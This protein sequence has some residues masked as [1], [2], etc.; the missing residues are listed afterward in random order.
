MD[1]LAT[2]Y[3]LLSHAVPAGTDVT[4]EKSTRDFTNAAY[5]SQGLRSPQ[6]TAICRNPPKYSVA[7]D[8]KT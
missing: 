4:Q 2:H 6:V 5:P 3:N 7:G 8:G 1:K